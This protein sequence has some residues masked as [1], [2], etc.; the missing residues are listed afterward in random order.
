M[1]KSTK[2]LWLYAAILLLIAIGL[3]FLTTLTQVRLVSHNGTFEILGTFTE[4][5][6]QNVARLTQEN[7][8][9]QNELAD[10]KEKSRQMATELETIKASAGADNTMKATIANIYNAYDKNDTETLQALMA[11]VTKEQLDAYLPGFYDEAQKAVL[12]ASTTQ[13]SNNKR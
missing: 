11:T 4:N 3:I 12:G 8:D 5:A 13:P 2:A 6:S 9:L 1:Q 7:I 10:L